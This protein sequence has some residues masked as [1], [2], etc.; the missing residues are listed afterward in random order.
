L[1]L[2]DTHVL[3]WLDTASDRLGSGCRAH[4]EQAHGEGEVAVS[5][6]SLWEVA[7]QVDRGRLELAVPLGTWRQDLLSAGV[8]EIPVD[9]E[10]GILAATLA[11]FHGDLADRILTATAILLQAEL[12]SADRQILAWPG[13]LERID[14][15]L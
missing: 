12:A 1:I 11:G 15:R 9:G 2:L 13:T 6:I 5:A 7:M 4:I 8:R 10:V 3:V 14:A